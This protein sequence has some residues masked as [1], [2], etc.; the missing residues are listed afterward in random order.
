LIAVKPQ[1]TT[2]KLDRIFA[3]LGR[4]VALLAPLSD[5][6]WCSSIVFPKAFFS[7]ESIEGVDCVIGLCPVT[8]SGELV[9]IDF[10]LDQLDGTFP[11]RIEI[12]LLAQL[13]IAPFCESLGNTI[14]K[15]SAE[16]IVVFLADPGNAERRHE[17]APGS[18]GTIQDSEGGDERLARSRH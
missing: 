7:R 12:G 9:R 18:V 4:T 11:A 13:A 10:N 8:K 17:I 2:H 15:N 16:G 3:E 6:R 1:E 5:D 14:F